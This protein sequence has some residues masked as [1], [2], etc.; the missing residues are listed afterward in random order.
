M[1]VPVALENS[2]LPYSPSIHSRPQALL[3]TGWSQMGANIQGD[4]GSR[5]CSRLLCLMEFPFLSLP[6][7]PCDGLGKWGLCWRKRAEEA[8]A[9]HGSLN[10]HEVMGQ[11][12][13]RA[14]SPETT[15]PWLFAWAKA[16]KYSS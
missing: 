13:N 5:T 7:P 14:K 9:P 10:A 4:I 15:T 2:I 6:S 8:P 3:P 12:V 1:R 16:A 11:L